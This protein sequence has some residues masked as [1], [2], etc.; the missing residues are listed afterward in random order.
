MNIEYWVFFGV[1]I[2]IFATTFD[3]PLRVSRLFVGMVLGI[4]GSLIGGITAYFMYGMTINGID[5]SAVFITGT[6]AVLLILL[7]KRIEQT[8]SVLRGGEKDAGWSV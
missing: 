6:C 4:V 8:F 1:I 5:M 7:G 2:S 3:L